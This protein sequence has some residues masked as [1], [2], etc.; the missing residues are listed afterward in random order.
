[1]SVFFLAALDMAF[2]KSFCNSFNRF[3]M[4][5]TVLFT[6]RSTDASDFFGAMLLTNNPTRNVQQPDDGL[7]Q[8][9]NTKKKQ[10]VAFYFYFY[11]YLDE[12]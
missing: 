6:R 12:K 1:M 3:S 11:T 4:F 7:R 5:V 9:G 10:H 2:R 8:C